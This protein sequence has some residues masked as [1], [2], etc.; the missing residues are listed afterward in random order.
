[1]KR[2][3]EEW[4]NDLPYVNVQTSGSTG[5][6]KILQVSKEMMRRSARK[7]LQYFD[8]KPGDTALLCL[9]AD[10]IAGKMMIVRA[11]EG[12]LRLITVEPSSTPLRD[13][14]GE[15]DFA[16]MVPAQVF[17]ELKT[18]GSLNR[19]RKLLIGGMALSP[20]LEEALQQ[21]TCEAC[22]SYGMTETVSHIALRRLNGSSRQAGFAPLQGV[23]VS[24]DERDCL[25]IDC[26]DLLENSLTTN[27]VAEILPSG[28]FR[29]LGRVDNVIN[30]GGIKIQP[31]ETERKIASFF[32]SPFAI[33][34]VSDEKFGE[35]IVLVAGEN[36]SKTKLNEINNCLNK[37]EK[38]HH[39][40]HLPELPQ[41]A[42]H[43]IDRR[44]L[45]NILEQKQYKKTD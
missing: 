45:K 38:L 43:K 8:L 23:S 9:S 11:L 26:P 5:T 24:L 17:E 20:A 10:Y 29:I 35:K 14:T 42:T 1:M 40:F 18:G 27:D 22:E 3:L 37:S 28:Q 36:I 34:S 32:S 39:A 7:T 31:E 33:S 13:F 2:F 25:V 21:C 30:S 6:P 15:V 4:N 16:A 41:T 19:V 44:Q 12:N